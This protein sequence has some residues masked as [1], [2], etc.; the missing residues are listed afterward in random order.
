M[1][2]GHLHRH[3]AELLRRQLVQKRDRWRAVLPQG[4]AAHLARTAL[5]N[6]PTSVVRAVMEDRAPVRLLKSFARR[7]RY[8]HD[9]EAARV[10]VAAWLEPGGR[11]HDVARLARDEWSMFEAV[12]PV[13][14]DLTLDAIESAADRMGDAAFFGSDAYRRSELVGL[15]HALAYD[16]PMF[17]RAVWLMIRALATEAAD[18]RDY[19]GRDRVEALFSPFPSG[20]H[21]DQAQRL[22]MIDALLDAPLRR[23]NEIGALA[24][25][26]MLDRHHRGFA[27]WFDFGAR[28]RD[29]G[30][31]PKTDEE[32]ADWFRTA[33]AKAVA[34]ADPTSRHAVAARAML[35][36]RLRSLWSVPLLTA[37]VEAAVRAVADAAFWPEGWMAVCA[38]IKF[39]NEAMPADSLTA[40]RAVERDLRPA[41]TVQAV[42]AYVLSDGAGSFDVFDA[43]A[44]E[45]PDDFESVSR[46]LT[47][48]FRALGRS[49]ADDGDALDSL[50]PDLVLRQGGN[51]FFLGR[52]LGEAAASLV[53]LWERM[54]GAFVAAPADRRDPD[55]LSGFL[56]AAVK[57]DAAWVGEILDEAVDHPDLGP[58]FPSLQTAVPIGDAG[59]A[60]L[61]RAFAVG[62]APVQA[63]QSLRFVSTKDGLSDEALASLVRCIAERPAGHAVATEIFSHRL[64]TAR[65]EGGCPVS[66]ALVVAGLALLLAYDFAAHRLDKDYGLSQ[67]VQACLASADVARTICRT[68]AEAAERSWSVI[69]DLELTLTALAE[70]QPRTFLD[71]FLE[72]ENG[73]TAELLRMSVRRR[74]GALR[75][76]PHAVLLEWADASPDRRYPLLA[77]ELGP[78]VDQ[79][80]EVETGAVPVSAIALDLLDRAPGRV[81]ILQA[82]ERWL[83]PRLRIGP[84][85][86][87]LD[88]CRHGLAELREHSDETVRL[89][90]ARMDE[91]LAEEDVAA[92]NHTR[93]RDRREQTF[94]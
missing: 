32:K 20:T 58:Y 86:D 30:W 44:M 36:R 50:L 61:H 87:V 31:R 85:A 6:I 82:F 89:W 80:G 67:I 39:R 13:R 5:E 72:A 52:F 14:P 83:T 28:P 41:T 34:L 75:S 46:R 24:L 73:V 11:L 84:W 9:S 92:R 43:E 77:A 90:A 19:S 33:L 91:V 40:L 76:I 93:E 49:L 51:R 2:A 17:D 16:A 57:R 3:V 10:V 94:E 21:A 65:D 8:L 60:R 63:Y 23:F 68:I 66:P 53:V 29:Y 35:A 48:R 71:Q 26:A 38:G 22:S 70:R 27:H 55:L 78:F 64:H 42:R 81:A 7:L 56:G 1:G 47:E 18:N 25:G 4:L 54:A 79:A 59:A 69:G 37:D 12:A 62:R 88:R 15:L 45:G 74:P